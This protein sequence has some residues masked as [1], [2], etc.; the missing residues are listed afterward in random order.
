[1]QIT[2]NL[3]SKGKN[4]S[5]FLKKKI[6]QLRS[7]MGSTFDVKYRNHQKNWKV[8]N[9]MNFK[10]KKTFLNPTKGFGLSLKLLNKKKVQKCNQCLHQQ[11]FCYSHYRRHKFRILIYSKKKSLFFF[12]FITYLFFFLS[13]IKLHSQK[14][15]NKSQ[16]IFWL[17]KNLRLI[18][19]FSY[20]LSEASQSKL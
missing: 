10:N 17:F 5:L 4:A 16:F 9:L 13:H 11:A 14:N 1:M 6:A 15:L 8:N 18:L 19:Y 2:L 20:Q 7:Q 3:I 12:L